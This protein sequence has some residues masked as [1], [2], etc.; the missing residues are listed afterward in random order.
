V[1]SLFHISSSVIWNNLCKHIVVNV[2][3]S[4]YG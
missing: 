4:F 3:E 1:D 2:F